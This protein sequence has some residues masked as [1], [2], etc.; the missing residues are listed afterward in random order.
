MDIRVVA[1]QELIIRIRDNCTAFDP[2]KRLDMFSVEDPC[3][4]IGIRLTASIARDIDYYNNA[5][6]NTL[7]MVLSPHYQKPTKEALA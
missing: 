4:N 1:R 5:C 7:I 2:R 3:R 6:V